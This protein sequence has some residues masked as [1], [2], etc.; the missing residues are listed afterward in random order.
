LGLVHF[1][2]AAAIFDLALAGYFA[3]Q[4]T[5]TALVKMA[6]KVRR[7]VSC[8]FSPTPTRSR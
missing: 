7:R 8:R 4:E 1:Q 2:G 6:R 3:H 5:C